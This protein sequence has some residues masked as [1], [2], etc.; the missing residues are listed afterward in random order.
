MSTTEATVY[1][2][3]PATIIMFAQG[4]GVPRGALLTAANLSEIALQ[5]PDELVPYDALLGIWQLLVKTF[6]ERALGLEYAEVVPLS[7]FGALGYALAHSP[8]AG[9][10]LQCYLRFSRL[11]DPFF[12]LELHPVGTRIRV[13]LDHEP[14]VRAMPEV[15]EMLV[16]ATHR[17]AQE[18]VFGPGHAAPGSMQVCFT[19]RA[20]HD[21]QTYAAFFGSAPVRFGAAYNG[22][23]FD[24]ALLEVAI[25]RADPALGRHL[26]S[27]LEQLLST[28]ASV[29]DQTFAE[30]VC[31]QLEGGLA[32]G[33]TQQEQVARRLKVSVRTL[34]RRLH[35]EDTSFQQVLEQLR[36]TQAAKLLQQPG[37]TVQEVAY[38]LG[39]SEPRAFHR[40]FRR[41]TGVSPGMWRRQDADSGAR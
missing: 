9:D 18:I 17:H 16:A 24:A 20:Q 14:R 38:L 21:A 31:A 39:Y 11:L 23:E 26:V 36:Q 22:V 4:L 41:W 13:C 1:A 32:E 6:P 12:E 25:P 5:D 2:S 28:V 33:I 34:Q 10:A 37:L 8:T 19:H 15:M 35:A 7:I 27:H 30:Q 40:S 29:P 3:L